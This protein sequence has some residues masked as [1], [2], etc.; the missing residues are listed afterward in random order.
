MNQ[1]IPARPSE[2]ASGHDGLAGTW[3][4]R[5]WYNFCYLLQ[6]NLFTIGFS[7]RI[8]GAQHVPRSGPVLVVANHQSFL[9]PVALGLAFPRRLIYLARKGLFDH[10]VF[11]WLIRSLNAVPIDQDGVGKEGIR[12]VLEQLK[13]GKAV[14]LFPEG[15]RTSTGHMVPLKPGVHLLI[16]RARAPIIPIGLAGA[17]DAWPRRHTLPI[18]AP[19]FWPPW[20]GTI[21]VSIGPALDPDRLASLPRGQAL[22]ELFAAIAAAKKRAEKLRRR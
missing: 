7:L 19:L 12:T 3:S 2:P 10:P 15:E 5:L 20:E 9:D 14:L 13:L 6:A 18:P 1:S 21:A 4:A 8:E 16:K 11:A 22:E 17:F